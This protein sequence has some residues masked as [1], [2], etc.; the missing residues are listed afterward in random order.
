MPAPSSVHSTAKRAL[1]L[2]GAGLLLVGLSPLL[3]LVALSVWLDDGRPILFAQTRVGR[4]GVPFRLFKFRTLTHEPDDPV[5][6]AAHTTGVGG[7]LRR[8]ALDELPQLWNVLRGEMSL[9]GPRPTVPDQV[10]RYGPHERRR[11]RVRPGLTGWAQ[12]HG[13]NALLWP[14]RID[15]DVWYVRN[16]SL[17]LDLQILARTPLILV[18]GVGVYGA[19]AKNPS[20]SPGSQLHA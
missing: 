1:D 12:I 9:V 18:R 13:R 5:R 7:V 17:R 16:R 8:W 11:L 2:V 14:E 6:A 19:D 10:A 20:F 4:G 3:G 15:R